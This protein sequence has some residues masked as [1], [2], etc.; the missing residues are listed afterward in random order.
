MKY[1]LY[2]HILA[3]GS[4]FYI[5]KGTFS[6]EGSYK[7]YQRAYSKQDRSKR[8]KEKAKNGYRIEI[9]EESDDET[10]ILNRE[11]ELSSNCVDCV[12]M[13]LNTKFTNYVIV[14]ISSSTALLNIFK[15]VYV[16]TNS[17]NILNSY[18]R[19]MKA[20]SNG[21]GYLIVT[22]SMGEKIKKNFYVHRLVA[23]AF[24]PNPLNFPIVNHKDTVKNNNTFENLEWCN[25]IENVNHS[26]KMG[27]Y[28]FKKRRKCVMQFDIEGNLLKE[29]ECT[30]DPSIEYR[31]TDTSIQTA[32]K[33]S[34]RKSSLS[35]G[36]LWIYKE[37]YDNANRE[38]F[39][40]TLLKLKKKYG[41][42]RSSKERILE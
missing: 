16:I 5:G 36:Y 21:N 13:Q 3:D 34:N 15:K 6:A 38:K 20:N 25:Q 9:V 26:V 19:K 22:F 40:K 18:G 35:K 42:N 31:C 10:Y 37:D 41:N 24:I 28:V 27:N 14:K 1:Y 17:G 7:G 12:N 2:S 4:V 11:N 23:E 29:W 33:Q 32:A 30:K 39:D 8:W